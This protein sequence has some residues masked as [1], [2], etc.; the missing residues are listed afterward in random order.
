MPTPAN[1]NNDEL[2]DSLRYQVCTYRQSVEEQRQELE[3]TFAL[4]VPKWPDHI[5]AKLR[6]W[7][8]TQ[9]ALVALEEVLEMAGITIDCTDFDPAVD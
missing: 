8:N 1:R 2:F 3:E 5:Q 4:P 9:Y 7:D 6:R